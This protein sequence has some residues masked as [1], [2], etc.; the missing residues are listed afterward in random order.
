MI[1]RIQTIYLLVAAL[2]AGLM[3]VVPMARFSTGAEAFTLTALG[4]RNAAGETV[5]PVVYLTVLVAVAALLPLVTIFLYKRRF[6]QIRFCAAEL[7]LLFGAGVVAGIYYYLCC[8]FFADYYEMSVHSMGAA[9][10]F[11]LAALVFDY[12]AL[13]GVV[14]DEK[15]VRSLDR[16]R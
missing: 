1:Q 8:R 2:F 3:F 12:L 4:L 5:Q 9:L 11:P 16:I 7:V 13:R 15:L 14:R 6:V 10:L